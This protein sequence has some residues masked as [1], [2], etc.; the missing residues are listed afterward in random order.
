VILF[1]GTYAALYLVVVSFPADLQ[2]KGGFTNLVGH[3][4]GFFSGM[5]IHYWQT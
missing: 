4:E 5:A 1:F 3:G 2:N